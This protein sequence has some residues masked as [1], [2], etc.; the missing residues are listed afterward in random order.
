MTDSVT[1]CGYTVRQRGTRQPVAY[2]ALPL[3]LRGQVEGRIAGTRSET[4][5]IMAGAVPC[6]SSHFFLDPLPDGWP[7]ECG[8]AGR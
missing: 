6:P 1:A 7:V 2:L 4:W 5:V 3:V 8:E